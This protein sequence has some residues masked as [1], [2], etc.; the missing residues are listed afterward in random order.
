MDC[1]TDPAG[2]R[3]AGTGRVNGK[4]SFMLAGVRFS[5]G[6]QRVNASRRERTIVSR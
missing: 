6:P 5:G 2:R 4:R 3:S 1:R